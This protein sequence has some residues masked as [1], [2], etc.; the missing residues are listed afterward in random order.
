MHLF[1]KKKYCF[2]LNPCVLQKPFVSLK[3]R[4]ILVF[5][6]LCARMVV[7]FV[8]LAK[9]LHFLAIMNIV[10]TVYFQNNFKINSTS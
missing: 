8:G 4:V 2:I 10:R 3:E 5:I 6:Y 1:I 7:I 9:Y